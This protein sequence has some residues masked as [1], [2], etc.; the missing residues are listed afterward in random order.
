MSFSVYLFKCDSFGLLHIQVPM[1]TASGLRVRFLKVISLP[2]QHWYAVTR[3][4]IIY[5]L[6]FCRYGKRADTTLLS[7]F[8]ISRKLVHT[9]LGARDTELL[10]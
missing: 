3:K 9:R 2:C 8:A 1:F 6:I 10:L 4:C 7:G 5:S